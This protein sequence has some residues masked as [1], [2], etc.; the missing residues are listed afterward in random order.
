MPQDIRHL[1]GKREWKHS[2]STP[3]K[4][5]AQQGAAQLLDWTDREIQK[6][7]SVRHGDQSHEPNEFEFVS[8]I[9]ANMHR[10]IWR[11]TDR[12]ISR[13]KMKEFDAEYADRQNIRLGEE[14][15]ALSQASI[16]GSLVRTAID[17]HIEGA[18]N[19]LDQAVELSDTDR[20]QLSREYIDLKRQRIEKLQKFV[21]GEDVSSNF[22]FN[23]QQTLCELIE[24]YETAK[25]SQS[26]R[27]ERTRIKYNNIA[28]VFCSLLGEN[29]PVASIDRTT[30]KSAR[31][32]IVNLPPN[33]S[34]IRELKGLSAREASVRAREL[35]LC[36][37][38]RKT[39]RDYLAYLTSLFAFALKEGVVDKNEALG[40]ENTS[41]VHS[42][43]RLPFSQEQ[44]EDIFSQPIFTGCVDD[45]R[46]WRK[47]GDS[48]PRNSKFWIPLVGLFS[49]MRL[50]EICGLEV[51]D[52]R[53]EDGIWYFD[54]KENEFRRLK[55]KDS[56]RR[57]PI[58]QDLVELGF[59]KWYD[60]RR[61]LDDNLLFSDLRRY[62]SKEFQNQFSK[63]FGRFRHTT[64]ASGSQTTF[65]SF[66]HYFEDRMRDAELSIEL[67]ERLGGWKGERQQARYGGGFTILKLNNAMQKLK[68]EIE[69]IR[70]LKNLPHEFY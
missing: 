43:D 22:K 69:A 35:K 50:G 68:F 30:L 65:H 56:K 57:V 2:L 54:I 24:E 48:H 67:N 1:V 32:V 36:R 27:P 11:E 58:H 55:N 66:R 51:E 33:F 19:G 47:T 70:A 63:W 15:E 25:A 46:N 64:K 38:S 60:G 8:V 26:K 40:I 39:V 13:L 62:K 18:S 4:L 5:K 59:L 42:E 7:R 61:T 3:D 34:K 16:F 9:R 12:E 6:F 14:Q 21:T 53:S 10:D 29:T 49:G 44:L 31:D 28:S 37:L 52:V 17:R 20:A 41:D 23:K 45:D